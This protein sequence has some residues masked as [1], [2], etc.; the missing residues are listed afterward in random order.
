VNNEEIPDK[1]LG[2]I[3]SFL[4]LLQR[5]MEADK[6]SENYGQLMRLLPPK[7]VDKYHYVIQW[8]IL[9]LVGMNHARRGR[10]GYHDIEITDFKKITDENG[11]QYWVKVKVRIVPLSVKRQNI[12]I[13]LNLT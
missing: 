10:E 4:A 7:F 5:I 12:E 3:F 8:A 1:S 11:F 13:M 6:E 2:E 9:F